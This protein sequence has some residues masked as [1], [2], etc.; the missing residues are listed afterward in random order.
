MVSQMKKS[1]LIEELELRSRV[2]QIYEERGI[3]TKKNQ[4]TDMREMV[5]QLNKASNRKN[6]LQ[7][8][9]RDLGIPVTGNETKP[10][11]QKAAMIRIYEKRCTPDPMD[12]VGFGKAAAL[13][14]AEIRSDTQYCNW[15]RAT[16]KED[17][18][19]CCPQLSRLAQWLI[20]EERK[21]FD[22]K[23]AEILPVKTQGYHHD[24]PTPMV[25]PAPTRVRV[26]QESAASSA[27]SVNS[28]TAVMEMMGILT[29]TVK[30]LK[31]EVAELSSQKRAHKT[32]G[33][34]DSFTK[35]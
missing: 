16:W 29:E 24:E 20:A 12:P 6:T 5:V 4:R 26:K 33:S 9:C 28:S 3:P 15:V 18:Q 13:T 30:E 22:S 35:T 7:Q 21:M 17:P 1:E 34:D 32:P 19:R 14:Y 25:T 11:L 10:Q 8:H 23:D 31:E 27:G 2:L